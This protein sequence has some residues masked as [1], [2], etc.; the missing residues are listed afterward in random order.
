MKNI[1]QIREIS[2]LSFNE[3]VL[4]EAED[5]LNPLL[6]RLKFLGIFSS[7][8]DE[9]FK[10]RVASVQR[11]I[12][13]GKKSMVA[14]LDHMNEKAREL[15]RRFQEAYENIIASLDGEGIRLIDEEQLAREKAP[16]KAWVNDYFRDTVLPSLV[17]II[18]R[19]GLPFPQ[20]TDGA[21]Y[22]AVMMWGSAFSY[23][24]L[25]LP[26]ALARFV[27]L[28]NG[29]IM[30]VD[31]VIRFALHEIFYIFNYESIGAYE[32]K[33]SRDAELDMDNDFSEGYVRKMEKVL[34][35]RKGGRPTRFVYDNQM[36]AELLNLLKKSLRLG[37]SD[38]AIGGG[39]YH[40]MRDLM[41]FP[42][43]RKDLVFEPM[44]PHDHP[45]LDGERKPMLD[46]MADQDVLLT[47]PYQSFDHV[48]RLLREAAIDPE[49]Q[50]IK[51]TV[52][53]L[54]DHSQIINALLNAAR[55]GKKVTAVIELQ[56]RFDEQRNISN[57]ARLQE[58][59]ATVLYGVPPMKVHAKLVLINRAGKWFSALSTGNLNETTARLYVDSMLFT[60]RKRIASD[61]AAV[62]DYFEY[63][64]AS[65]TLALPK[66]KHLLVSPFNMRKEFCR[67]IAEETRKG[68]E[69]R[70]LFKTNHLTDSDI[71]K[72]LYE[73]AAAGVA[74]DLVVRTTCAI[75]PG[76][77]IR[78]IS[79][80][81][82][83]LEHQRIYAF[84]CGD[85]AR[86]FMSSS[87][88]MERNLDWRVEAAFPIYDPD[89][90][91]QVLDMVGIQIEDNC[92][93]RILDE[94][95]QNTY[96]RGR[97]GGRRAQYATYAYFRANQA[98][99]GQTTK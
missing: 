29:C 47:Y 27:E 86:V 69:G 83:F 54:A 37:L 72:R 38:T 36:P 97:R 56:A 18:I 1:A 5:P 49:V 71:I 66:F 87:D 90:K 10:V 6:E 31:D 61:V 34:L 46:I 76:G 51:T 16:V 80:L 79:I 41:R 33:I 64:P 73:A 65:R 30:Y 55:N 88:L 92:K 3:R 99:R 22:F 25:E 58:V 85:E 68:K 12:E 4:Q 57:S 28:P 91:R 70:I 43:K 67:L 24:L 23:A 39:R 77:N 7:N 96:V 20:L 9:F 40:N 44:E 98:N 50:E 8:M 74:V 62:F 84:G 42:G 19:D 13:M 35:Q 52:Y 93:A 59:G 95:Q 78:A 75:I 45:V 63:T 17:P 89:I 15:D 53:R 11:R 48:I 14:V 2:V 32:F 21:V 81:D 26:S 82:R 94:V 60:G